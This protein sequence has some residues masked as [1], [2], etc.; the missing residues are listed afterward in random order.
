MTTRWGI[1]GT[2]FVARQFAASLRLVNGATI[3]Q[4]AS[5]NPDNAARF[6]Q[7]FGGTAAP[8]YA[9]LVAAPDVDVIYISTPTAYHAAHATQCLEGKKAVLCEKP[10]ATSPEEV[11]AVIDV[12]RRQSCF[13]MEAMWTRFLPVMQQVRTRVQA[14]ELGPVRLLQ[15]DLSVPVPEDPRDARYRDDPGAGALLDLG[16]YPVSLA[17]DL[18]GR[19]QD[20]SAHVLRTKAGVDRQAVMTLRYPEATAVLTTGFFGRGRNDATIIG[21]QGRMQLSAPLY[22]PERLTTTGWPMP[23]PSAKS[24]G[25]GGRDMRRIDKV[26]ERFGWLPPLYRPALP[27]LRLAAGRDKTSL[28]SFSGFG[29]QFEAEEVQRQLHAGQ[30]ES[31]TMRWEDSVAIQ[32]ILAA[33][34]HAS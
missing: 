17:L 15:A 20:V 16:V 26:L 19:P 2:G 24:D 3:T 7:D 8:N 33:V 28:H 23:S 6:A 4:V 25:A 27:L 29:Y 32:E 11:K 31:P 21:E 30:P 1:M 12:A 9:S 34:R 13:L 22:A 5:R 18:L 10:L 14:G